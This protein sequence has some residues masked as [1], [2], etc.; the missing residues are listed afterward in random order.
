MDPLATIGILL[1]MSSRLQPIFGRICHMAPCCWSSNYQVRFELPQTFPLNLG[2]R[3]KFVCC[4]ELCACGVVDIFWSQQDSFPPRHDTEVNK[5]DHGHQWPSKNNF[6]KPMAQSSPSVVKG[7]RLETYN[8]HP[9]ARNSI[10][11]YHII[12]IIMHELN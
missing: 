8:H 3:D 4:V 7:I 9:M 1:H 10:D 11:I 12:I 2:G 5:E 6:L